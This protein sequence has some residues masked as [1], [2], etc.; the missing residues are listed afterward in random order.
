VENGVQFGDLVEFVDFNYVE[1]VREGERLRTLWSLSQAPG[2]PKNVQI[3]APVLTNSTLLTW[4]A[5]TDPDLDG[6]EVVWRRRARR[7]GPTPSRWG[8]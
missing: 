7:T 4:D 5:N 1:R 2:T 3:H 8:T 6:Y